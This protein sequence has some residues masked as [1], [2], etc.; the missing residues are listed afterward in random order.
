MTRRPKEA[1]IRGAERRVLKIVRAMSISDYTGRYGMR[2]LGEDLFKL[3]GAQFQ[4][5]NMKR[6]KEQSSG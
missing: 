2:L 6:T 5:T 1:A 3:F 4:L